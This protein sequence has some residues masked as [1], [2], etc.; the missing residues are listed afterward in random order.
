[1]SVSQHRFDTNGMKNDLLF[2]SEFVFEKLCTILFT[3]TNRDEDVMISSN[4]YR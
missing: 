3:N 1:M 2:L 4:T